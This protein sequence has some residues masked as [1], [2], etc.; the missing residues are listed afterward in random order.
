[1][2]RFNA[3]GH[4]FNL[5]HGILFS[6][7]NRNNSDLECEKEVRR[8]AKMQQLSE[9]AVSRLE[10][11]SD[12]DGNSEELKAWEKS[13]KQYVGTGNMLQNELSKRMLDSFFIKWAESQPE[14]TGVHASAIL[15]H[16]NAFCLRELVLGQFFQ[17]T[18]VEIPIET[19]AIFLNGWVLHR[20]WQDL[21]TMSMEANT[22]ETTHYIDSTDGSI[23]ISYTPD[24][25]DADDKIVEI[26]GYRSD[27]AEA[28]FQAPNPWTRK[29]YRNAHLQANLYMH[30]SQRERA[31]VLIENKNNQRY[32]AWNISYDSALAAPYLKRIE[33]LAY[34][35]HVYERTEKVV[36]RIPECSSINSK[37]ACV[38]PLRNVCF[39]SR[40]ERDAMKL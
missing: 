13:Q 15:A 17:K 20:K 4:D 14:R 28:C 30:F 16:H 9:S 18:P 37:R 3:V 19:L 21:Y 25:E 5:W 7:P 2:P 33:M 38:C 11:L 27:S 40:D 10:E 35:I 29:E 36:K 26:K 31:M 34:V 39:A 6:P 12:W 1:M 22:V 32:Q 23:Q 24:V 8:E